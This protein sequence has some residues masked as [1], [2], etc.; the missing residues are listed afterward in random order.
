[1]NQEFW[2]NWNIVNRLNT[3]KYVRVIL[4]IKKPT[5]LAWWRMHLLHSIWGMADD[6]SDVSDE[7]TPTIKSEL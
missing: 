5:V 2:I 4:L 3:G 7:P 1:M 6:V